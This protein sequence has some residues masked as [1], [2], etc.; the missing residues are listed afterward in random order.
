MHV[1]A[2]TPPRLERVQL[3][4]LIGHMGRRRRWRFGRF[5]EAWWK[6]GGTHEGRPD[7]A[8]LDWMYREDRQGVQAKLRV[9]S[10]EAMNGGLGTYKLPAEQPV[11]HLVAM[12]DDLRLQVGVVGGVGGCPAYARRAQ[13][14]QF[15]I[16][17]R[18]EPGGLG[19]GA[20]HLLLQR[21]KSESCESY[22]LTKALSLSL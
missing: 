13:P 18:D 5:L 6:A 2:P 10:M 1:A 15:H 22:S 19:C 16:R 12:S 20:Q 14:P 7:H 11:M 4:L 9:V 21:A 3:R 17:P 8:V